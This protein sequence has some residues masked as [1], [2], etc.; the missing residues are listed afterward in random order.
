M[1]DDACGQGGAF[2]AGSF[3]S[4]APC[5][6]GSGG[7]RRGYL[8]KEEGVAGVSGRVYLDWN[9][10]APVRPEARAA[11]ALTRPECADPDMT[12]V[13]RHAFDTWRTEPNGDEIISFFFK[14]VA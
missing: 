3:V 8:E 6:S 5:G 11:L 1:N 7:L 12:P 4:P 9:A 14:P 10:T 2:R 13:Q